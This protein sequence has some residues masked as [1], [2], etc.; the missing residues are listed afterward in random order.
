VLKV[1]AVGKFNTIISLISRRQEQNLMELS[2][3]LQRG[4]DFISFQVGP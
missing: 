2:K 4:F 1:A 3:P